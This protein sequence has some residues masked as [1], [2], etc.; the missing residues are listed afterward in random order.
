[1]ISWSSKQKRFLN[2][3]MKQ[4]WLSQAVP[5]PPKQFQIQEAF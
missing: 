2:N 3:Q 1:M 5:D 4:H